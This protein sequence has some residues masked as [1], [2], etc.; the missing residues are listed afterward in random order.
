MIAWLA[1]SPV[2]A[3]D[4][5]AGK[6]IDFIVG[7]DVG[8]GYDIYARV[9]ARHLNRFIPGSPTIV[10]KN[11]PGA[12]SGRAASFLYS[13][14]PKDGTVIGAV[15]PGAVMGPLLDDRAQP[16]YDPTKF[17][18]LGSADNATRVCITH[19]RSAIK[20][21]EDT[22]KQKTIMGASAAGGSTRD[23]INMLKKATGAMFE[24]VAGYKGTADIFLAME[25]GEVDGMCGLD[26]ASLK[27]QR[28]DWVRNRT[29][30]ILAQINLEPEAELSTLGVPS[31]WTFIAR[32]SDKK[33]AELI[34]SQQ[35]FGR[36]YLAPPGVAAEPLAVLRTAFAATLQDKEFLADAERT[37]IDV[38]A[39]TGERVQQLVEQL[40]ATPKATVERA[41]ELIKP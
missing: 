16:L 9:V 38:V 34:V 17:Q 30:N 32:E 20:R 7:G 26:W 35:V 21:F 40:Y 8:G 25:R 19:E 18:Y 28:P 13:V 31:I 4:F 33:A 15:F 2:R 41:K 22:L 14:A 24:L 10:P 36:P 37:R 11:Q 5:Y 39:S 23:Y 1:A 12:G 6:T 29:V 27:S 3:A